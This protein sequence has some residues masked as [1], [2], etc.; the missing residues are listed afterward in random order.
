VPGATVP[1]WEVCDFVFDVYQSKGCHNITSRKIVIFI[2]AAVETRNHVT[3]TVFFYVCQHC[4]PRRHSLFSCCFSLLTAPKQ[5]CKPT[6]LVPK[7]YYFVISGILQ[8]QSE[9]LYSTPL[10]K[11]AVYCICA[12]IEIRVKYC[13]MLYYRRNLKCCIRRYYRVKCY[14]DT[15]IT[16]GCNAMFD[17][18]FSF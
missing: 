11:N 4:C 2:S 18:A 12:F 7:L 14:L 10:Q 8:I 9:M 15:I 3:T 1:R 13:V 5:A 6:L 16:T 17:N